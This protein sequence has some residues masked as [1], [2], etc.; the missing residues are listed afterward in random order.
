M[1]YIK[2]FESIRKFRIGDIVVPLKDTQYTNSHD[3]YV[4]SGEFSP[5][6]CRTV[7]KY[8]G[9]AYNLETEYEY[10]TTLFKEIEL[11]ESTLEEREKFRIKKITTNYNL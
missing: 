10:D 2:C 4:V 11:R 7:L 1:K 9:W 5:E 8:D 6:Y 3:A